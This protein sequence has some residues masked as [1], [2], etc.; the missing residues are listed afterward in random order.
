LRLEARPPG[1]SVHWTLKRC[2][3]PPPLGRGHPH[4]NPHRSERAMTGPRAGST[5][6]T[7]M[8]PAR[9]ARSLLDRPAAWWCSPTTTAL[10]RGQK[11]RS[12]RPGHA[13]GHAYFQVRPRTSKVSAWWC[14]APTTPSTADMSS[15]WMATLEPGWRSLEVLF[16]STGLRPP[17]RAASSDLSAFGAWSPAPCRWR[18]H[19]GCGAWHCP[20]QVLAKLANKLW[21][22]RIPCHG[23]VLIS[24]A[25]A[26][27]DPAGRRG[28]RRRLGHPARKLSRW[29]R[30]AAAVAMRCSCA[31]WPAVSCRP[32]PV[33]W[34]CACRQ[35]CADAAAC[36]VVA[37]A[38]PPSR[39]LRQA[40]LREP[41][42]A[43]A[44]VLAVRRSPTV[45]QPP[46][47]RRLRRQHPTQRQTIRCFVAQQPVHGTS[48]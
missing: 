42:R 45:H 44:P 40:E 16:R 48:F 29:C 4:A 8:P 3:T 31:R 27:P 28:D 26:D 12:P 32:R 30:R 36:R 13:H 19:L 34:V 22:S 15:G 11:R 17:A 39:N 2:R 14:A 46:P 10:H 5:A 7:S 43:A 20:L 1:L 25:V 38:R 47:P 37:G 21:P 9:R 18:R 24:E 33:W 35:D 23:G 6:T 41:I